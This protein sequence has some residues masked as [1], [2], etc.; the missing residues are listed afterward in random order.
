MCILSN[1]KTDIRI[2]GLTALFHH[3]VGYMRNL[4]TRAGFKYMEALGRIIIIYRPLSTLK[5]YNSHAL[6]I[7][8]ITKYICIYFYFV[9]YRNLNAKNEFTNFY[10]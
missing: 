8:I 7:V 4:L 6:T 2:N 5:C 9:K 3:S 10:I 1:N